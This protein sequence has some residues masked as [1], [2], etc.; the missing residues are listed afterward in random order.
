MLSIQSGTTIVLAFDTDVPVTANLQK[1][2]ELE[3]RENHNNP[4]SENSR[5]PY[6]PPEKEAAIRDA[7][8]YFKMI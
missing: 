7:L 1:N 2:L 3:V 4:K 6:C 8:K 5:Q